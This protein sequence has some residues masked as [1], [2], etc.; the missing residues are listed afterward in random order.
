MAL[1]LEAKAVGRQ[2][3]PEE[4]DQQYIPGEV[5]V[6]RFHKRTPLCDAA[7]LHGWPCSQRQEDI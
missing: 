4:Y 7:C 2:D 1:A 5:V 6:V 3:C